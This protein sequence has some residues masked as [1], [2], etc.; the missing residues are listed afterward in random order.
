MHSIIDL[1]P[2][3]VPILGHSPNRDQNNKD[4]N[5]R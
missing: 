3:L 1:F 2:I 4:D 5:N